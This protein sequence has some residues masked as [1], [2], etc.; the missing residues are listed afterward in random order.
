[1]YNPG[2]GWQNGTPNV[3]ARGTNVHE[4]RQT[5]PGPYCG[6]P[7]VVLRR[8]HGQQSS[9]ST[10]GAAGTYQLTLFRGVTP[11]VTD[12][13]SAGQISSLPNGGTAFTLNAP[14]QN[15]VAARNATG[16]I[17]ASTIDYQESSGT[18]LDSYQYKR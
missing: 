16:T 4:N 15:Q 7:V 11:P 14:A 1:M 13:Y 9:Q 5:V 3:N 2:R 17:S 18:S 8:L 6:D 10:H 12:T